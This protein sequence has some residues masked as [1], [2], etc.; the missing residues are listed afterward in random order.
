MIARDLMTNGAV[1]VSPETPVREVARL[2]LEHRISAVPVVDPAGAPLGIVSEG[3]LISRTEADRLARR[4]WWLLQIAN[5]AHHAS[6]AAP[7]DEV[8]ARDIMSGPVVTVT[9]TTEAAEIAQVLT[10]YH[11]KRVPVLRDGRVVGIVSRA[12]ILRGF[13]TLQASP[14][15]ARSAPRAGPLANAIAALE[16][17]FHRLRRRN[18]A[19]TPD[20][21]SPAA[22][23]AARPTVADF[24]ALIRDFEQQ[25]MR[26]EED[27]RMAA[28][29]QRAQIVN[30]LID[31]HVVDEEWQSRLLRAREAAE[32]GAKEFQL[33]RFPSS[34]CIDG[35][36]AVNAPLPD[37]PRTLRGAAAETYLRWERELKPHGFQ[38][39]ARV[40][41]FPSGMPGDIGLFIR[42]GE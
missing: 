31:R 25:Q 34:L 18:G 35:G 42:W 30:D 14:A 5:A 1:T 8:Y 2:L 23:P 39:T 7:A 40:L 22:Q 9:E 4:P 10:T 12:D 27:K 16:Q 28:A 38:L 6:S 24:R 36:R 19:A 21:A 13:V 17:R 29:Q 37:W 20:P 41:D 15:A 26:L 32:R 11:I 33:L 3:D